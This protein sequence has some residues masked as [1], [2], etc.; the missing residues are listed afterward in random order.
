[1]GKYKRNLNIF[2]AEN[3]NCDIITVP[4]DLL[5]KLNNLDKNLEKFSRETVTDFFNDAKKAG[6]EI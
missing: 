1:M 4:N 6:F 2:Q 5:N 3:L